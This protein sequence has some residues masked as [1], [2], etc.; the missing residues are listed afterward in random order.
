MGNCLYPVADDNS[1]NLALEE[2]FWSEFLETDYPDYN[3]ADM[4][5]AAP[6]HSC[7]LLDYSSLPFFILVSILGILAGGTFLYAL[8][9]PLFRWQLY[10]D[11][12]T[13]VQLAVGSALFSI[14]VPIL[15]RGLTGAP[16]TALCH[17]AHLVAY[18]SAFAQALLIGYHAY[19]G[20]Q[21]GA[22]QVPGLRLGI[23]MGLWGVATLLSLPVTLG[24]DTSQGLCTVT[25]SG[26]WEMLRYIHA[27]AC[28]A[29]FV[30]L[31]LG[32]LGAKGLKR[33]L[34]RVTCSWVDILWVWFIFWWPQGMSLGLDSLVRSRAI[35]VSTCPA[36]QA[37]DMLLDV[38]EA[39]AILH[40]VA[41][42]L[43]LA[44]VCHQATHTS[45]P[46]LPLST[47]QTSHLDTLGGKS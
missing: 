27:A 10:Q 2:G 13:L 12:S 34:G 21:L 26:E 7:P 47:T 11:R 23:T 28:F 5:A 16:I 9:R 32:L 38:A 33:A 4:E 45:P 40:C 42:P 18:G 25:F 44:W 20:P 35:V 41:T 31:P 1:T 15:A 22:G 37:L 14:V 3:E 46:S 30:L 6:C 39:L 19:L 29:V 43:L 36:Q 8:L 24:S 17:L